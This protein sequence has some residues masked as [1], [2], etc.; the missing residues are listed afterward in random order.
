[1]N[2]STRCSLPCGRL[3]RL[4]MNSIRCLVVPQAPLLTDYFRTVQA[5]AF[6][7]LPG[8][9]NA[10]A[11]RIRLTSRIAWPPDLAERVPSFDQII[12]NRYTP[13][14]VFAVALSRSDSPHALGGL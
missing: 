12:V 7:T 5:M 4:A 11:E 13:G 9:A 2:C 10:L 1:M 8:W 3:I 14:Q 6:G